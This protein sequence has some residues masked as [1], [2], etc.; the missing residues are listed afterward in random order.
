MESD[1]NSKGLQ[2]LGRGTLVYKRTLSSFWE[3]LENSRGVLCICNC[4][5]KIVPCAHQFC[6][7]KFLLSNTSLI[8]IH[9]KEF[10]LHVSYYLI[11]QVGKVG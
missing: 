1:L 10:M 9:K 8:E 3:R 6:N 7:R 2:L 11:T 5:C 4:C